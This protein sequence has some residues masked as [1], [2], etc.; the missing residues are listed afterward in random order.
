MVDTN[1]LMDCVLAD[2]H[3]GVLSMAALERVGLGANLIINPIVY[4]ELAGCFEDKSHL[5][6]LLSPY[7]FR[8]ESIPVDAAF[9]AGRV[10]RRYREQGGNRQ[11]ILPDFLIGAH[12]AVRG[13]GLLSRDRG[14]L[15]YFQ[16]EVL[17][18]SKEISN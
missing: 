5:D 15:R 9:L 10:F 3:F 12:A 7:L 4:A 14:Y 18:P 8:Y 16:L 6:A 1:I 2:P 17:D 13:Y 11:R